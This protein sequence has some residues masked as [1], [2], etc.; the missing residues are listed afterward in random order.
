MFSHLMVTKAPGGSTVVPPYLRFCFSGF[1]LPVLS[2]SPEAVD[3]PPDIL[4]EGQ[5]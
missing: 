2:R 3:P 5:Q 1:Q 4:S